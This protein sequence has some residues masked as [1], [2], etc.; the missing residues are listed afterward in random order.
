M[1]SNRVNS[2]KK[3]S[4]SKEEIF[5][6]IL[7]TDVISNEIEN[8]AFKKRA[9]LGISQTLTAVDNNNI[10]EAILL[11]NVT[12]V[13]TFKELIHQ[14]Y[15][16]NGITAL[17]QD[18]YTLDYIKAGLDKIGAKT[19]EVMGNLINHEFMGIAVDLQINTSQIGIA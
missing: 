9:K 5:A 17:V 14:G 3:V 13:F 8:P 19:N 6:Y 16:V 1:L 7:L 18:E 4:A 15:S 11:A 2:N 10:Q 12:I